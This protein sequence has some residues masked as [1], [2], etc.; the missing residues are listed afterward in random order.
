MFVMPCVFSVVW[1][2][3]RGTRCSTFLHAGNAD[4]L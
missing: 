4:W 3:V 2:P 1:T